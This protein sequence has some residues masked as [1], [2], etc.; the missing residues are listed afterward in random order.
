MNIWAYR[1]V[2]TALLI[3]AA[4]GLGNLIR[5]FVSSPPKPL[6]GHSVATEWNESVQRIGINP[7][8]PPQEDLHVGD[9][10]AVIKQSDE[11]YPTSVVFG[12]H[13][14]KLW[15]VDMT[16]ALKAAYDG[17]PVFPPTKERPIHDDDIW[18]QNKSEDLFHPG[19][20]KALSLVAFPAFSI[21]HSRA[22]TAGASAGSE[23]SGW[24]SGV[25]GITRNDEETEQLSFPAAETY[26]VNSI[27]AQLAL[28]SFCD[29]QR[30]KP[31][32]TERA[33]R[34]MLSM[35][36]GNEIWRPQI[37]PKTKQPTGRYASAVELM[38]VKQ[39]FL[40]RSIVQ[41][42]A[43]DSA[44][45]QAARLVAK[46][47]DLSDRPVTPPASVAPGETPAS[48][49]GTA[50]SVSAEAETGAALQLEKKN[51]LELRAM[52]DSQSETGG[53]ILALSADGT[54]IALKQVYPRPV[55]IGFRSVSQ[56]PL[57]DVDDK[58]SSIGVNAP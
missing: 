38:L 36:V 41:L 21:H 43:A 37:D 5:F 56:R 28:F 55:A 30:T 54:T 58:I 39:V 17:V 57:A 16:A 44:S 51:L 8:Y 2:V 53:S 10:F 22:G 32:C 42:R 46:L 23:I 33:V 29:D 9:I 49:P 50:S 52:L 26:G 4:I 6:D 13:A 19:N 3:L 14:I 25:F 20:K 12:D 35:V 15:H 47:K 1:S 27:Q 31:F 34:N 24:F 7:I 45:G 40:T 18:D 11:E 48:G